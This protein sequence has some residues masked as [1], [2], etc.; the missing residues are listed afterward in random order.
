[1]DF[2]NSLESKVKGALGEGITG[3]VLYHL[4]LK[5][6]SGYPYH[7]IYLPKDNDDYSEIDLAFVTKKALLVNVQ[8]NNHNRQT[9]IRIARYRK[10]VFI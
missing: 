8:E 3:A 4:C 5:G 1:M 7:N 6:Y 10:N 9:I 2:F